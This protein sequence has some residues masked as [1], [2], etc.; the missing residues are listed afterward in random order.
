MRRRAL[1]QLLAEGGGDGM[2]G[3]AGSE[4]ANSGS[5]SSPTSQQLPI[6]ELN[7]GYRVVDVGTAN[8][9]SIVTLT[10]NREVCRGASS[11]G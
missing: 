5:S 2:A 6:C 8:F 3:G 10:N 9:T 1:L 11:L 7:L 4:L